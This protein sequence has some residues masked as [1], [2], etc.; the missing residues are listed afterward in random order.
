M[1][2]ESGHRR[3]G[4]LDLSIRWGPPAPGS[5]GDACVSRIHPPPLSSQWAMDYYA[6]S[7]EKALGTGEKSPMDGFEAVVDLSR[8]ITDGH[9]RAADAQQSG[10]KVCREIFP[11]WIPPIFTSEPPGTR[12]PVP[13]AVPP[14]SLLPGAPTRPAPSTRRVTPARPGHPRGQSDPR[15]SRSDPPPERPTAP[16]NPQCSC[17]G[18]SPRPAPRSTRWGS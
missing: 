9:T 18:R 2:G 16:P 15:G 10:L 8:R 6:G 12:S 5:S 14:P 1:G 3:R 7:L 11:H 4:T 17:R 13:R